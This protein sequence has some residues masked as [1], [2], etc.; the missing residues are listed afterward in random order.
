MQSTPR[1]ARGFLTIRPFIPVPAYIECGYDDD[2]GTWEYVQDYQEPN[3]ESEDGYR[4]SKHGKVPRAVVYLSKLTY[5]G[6]TQF[7]DSNA[8]KRCEVSS[9][10]NQVIAVEN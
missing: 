6:K 9:Q 1:A 7:R 5:V 8:M 3:S 4:V 10:R 2:S